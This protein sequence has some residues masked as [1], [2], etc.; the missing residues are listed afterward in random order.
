MALVDAVNTLL[1]RG[2]IKRNPIFGAVAAVSVGVYK[3][4]PV[5][6]LDY[7]EDSDCDTDMN[8]V[9]NDG[10]GFIELQGTAEGHAF[11]RDELDAL[12]ALA[13]KGIGE[14]F[15]AQQQALSA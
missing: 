2:E 13:E 15:T 9:M 10:G 8:V 5:L 11:R 7:A 1:K 14:L 3:G 12:L 4:V 6:D